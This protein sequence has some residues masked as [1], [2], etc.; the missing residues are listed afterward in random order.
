MNVYIVF[1][2][3]FDLKDITYF[4]F[5]RVAPRLWHS[6]RICSYVPWTSLLLY[7]LSPKSW[8]ILVIR[9][10]FAQHVAALLIIRE[11]L[12]ATIT[13]NLG[14]H[15][16]SNLWDNQK[17]NHDFPAFLAIFCTKVSSPVHNVPTW[18]EHVT[19]KQSTFSWK[20]GDLDIFQN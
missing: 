6:D 9:L 8:A 16:K 4:T 12:P 3:V 10:L 20:I 17:S 11:N 5:G 13:A 19:S 7:I 1:I 14:H 2:Y 18:I 15:E